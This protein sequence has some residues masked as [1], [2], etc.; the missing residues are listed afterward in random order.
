M[1]EDAPADCDVVFHA[2]ATESG[3]ANALSCA[4]FE[5]RVVE[6]SWHGTKPVSIPLG[7]AFHSRRLSIIASQ[8]GTVAAR[9]RPRWNYSRRISAA[10]ALL[11]RP[12][13]DL[14]VN[15]EIAFEE[16][17]ARLPLIL[18]TDS[19]ALAPVIRYT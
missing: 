19:A 5:A 7:G 2:S 1:P 3:L 10:M 17:P 14:L 8:V 4:G 12:E 13:L 15:E 18:S 9:R 16:A 6:V 11:D